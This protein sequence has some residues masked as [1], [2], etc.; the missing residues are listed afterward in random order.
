M[1]IE[2]LNEA[3]GKIDASIVEAALSDGSSA[4]ATVIVKRPWLKW[5]AAAVAI[6]VFAVGTPLAL[7]MMGAFRSD[8]IVAPGSDSG[9]SSSEGD[10]TGFVTP[11]DDS[12]SGVGEPESSSASEANDGSSSETAKK[13]ANSASSSD[14]DGESGAVPGGSENGETSSSPGHPDDPATPPDEP[15]AEPTEG[16]FIKDDMPP[17]TYM[18][19]GEEKTFNYQR[20]TYKKK[21]ADMA[22]DGSNGDYVVDHY[23]AENGDAVLKN[24]DSEDLVQYEKDGYFIDMNLNVRISEE[25]AIEAAKNVVMNTDLPIG[26]LDN[27][28]VS[29]R[30]SSSRYYVTFKTAEGSVEVCLDTAGVLQY[31]AV[32]KNALQQL[33]SERVSAAIEKMNERLAELNNDPGVSYVLKSLHFEERGSSVYAVFDVLYYPDKDSDEYSVYQYYCIV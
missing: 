23:V 4:K 14:G 16:E 27:M 24:S 32:R 2:K 3:I 13:P 33:S 26:S 7:N 31:L 8:N 21:T 1:D 28:I 18:I 11:S 5:V 15:P 30:Y 20:S 29:V 10:N 17:V 12:S 22:L 6:V 25:G 9:D 19:N